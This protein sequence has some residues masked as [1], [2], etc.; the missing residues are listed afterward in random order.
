MRWSK[1][2]LLRRR[3]AASPLVPQVPWFWSDQYDVKLQM[4]GLSAGHDEAVVRGDPQ[5][6]RSFAVFYLWQGALIAVDAV[7]RAPEFMMSKQLIA[8]QAHLDPTKLRD[9]TVAVRDL[10]G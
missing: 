9:E 10:K 6:S 4:V 7:N 1:D 5:R 8:D 2:A 3:S